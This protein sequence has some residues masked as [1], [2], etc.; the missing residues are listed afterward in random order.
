M[1]NSMRFLLG[2]SSM[3]ALST[4]VQADP[5]LVPIVP[6]PDATTTSIFG[7][8]DDNNTIVGSYVANSDGL[9]HGF[10]GTV[11]GNYTSFDFGENTQGR[12]ID[13]QARV[14]TG[15][16]N[17]TGQHCELIEWEMSLR[18]GKIKRITKDGEPL[19]G[20]AMG[21]NGNKLFAGDYCDSDGVIHGSLDKKH[22]WKSDVTTPFDS[23][24]TGERAVDDK[25]TVVGF[26]VNPDT[27]LQIGTIVK[28]GVTS[29]VTYP[30]ANESY[31]VFEGLNGSGK[32]AAGQWGDTD[33]I[34][35]SF[36]YDMKHATFTQIDDPNAGSFT[37]AWGVNADGL[38]AVSSD[39]GAYIYCPTS[40]NCPSTGIK[41]IVLHPRTVH[42]SQGK[43]LAY[44]DVH[45]S[46]KH[47]A[48]KQ[49]LPKGASAQ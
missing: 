8:T 28:N 6:F 4:A 42:M 45:A 23:P 18:T 21:I 12:A 7:I 36:A 40:E 25:G 39:A 34:V 10:Y 17:T 38:I 22:Q 44:G 3:L 48:I 30:D 31:T 49:T 19:L 20:I 13:G 15:F 16:S 35:H 26:Y 37:Q 29:T 11:D 9:V 27:G 47:V 1:R 33:G 32:N 43:M 14:I 2:L 24:Y 41:A 46:T 5:Q